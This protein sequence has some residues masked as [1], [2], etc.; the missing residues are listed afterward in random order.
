MRAAIENYCFVSK[1]TAATVSYSLET[2]C[3]VPVHFVMGQ[4]DCFNASVAP[5]DNLRYN[6]CSGESKCSANF[7]STLQNSYRFSY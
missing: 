5:S 1:T 4:T 3:C 6:L 2:L 7:G